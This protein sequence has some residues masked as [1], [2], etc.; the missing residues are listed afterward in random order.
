MTICLK[1]EQMDRWWLLLLLCEVFQ[2]LCIMFNALEASSCGG[3]HAF[4]WSKV[5][6]HLTVF[7]WKLPSSG[8]F[9]SFFLSLSRSV[10]Y[11]SHWLNWHRFSPQCLRFHLS[12]K[13]SILTTFYVTQDRKQGIFFVLEGKMNACKRKARLKTFRL[14]AECLQTF[15]S[16]SCGGW[17][18]E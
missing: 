1:P 17:I 12:G 2:S 15:G 18:Y 3:Q 11:L 13:T 8:F 16:E 7:S 9:H 10:L 6:T 14:W 5:K 4:V